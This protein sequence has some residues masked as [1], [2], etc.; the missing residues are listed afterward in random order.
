MDPNFNQ[1]LSRNDP[2]HVDFFVP[3]NITETVVDT[4]DTGEDWSLKRVQQ[5][6]V[7][8]KTVPMK[9]M[10]QHGKKL[11]DLTEEEKALMFPQD[12][13]ESLMPI[14]D[15]MTGAPV[16]TG[17]LSVVQ[18]DSIFQE[19]FGTLGVEANNEYIPENDMD[20]TFLNDQNILPM[21]AYYPNSSQ[22]VRPM[23]IIERPTCVSKGKEVKPGVFVPKRGDSKYIHQYLDEIEYEFPAG[24]NW[25]VGV[26]Q[27]PIPSAGQSWREFAI[28]GF[29][30]N[31]D[32][33][34]MLKKKLEL[35]NSG[36]VWG[37]P[38]YWRVGKPM[39]LPFG[40]QFGSTVDVDGGFITADSRKRGRGLNVANSS[41]IPLYG[42]HGINS[43]V[44]S[45]LC[46]NPLA[47]HQVANCLSLTIHGGFADVQTAGLWLN[48]MKKKA[49]SSNWPD[50]FTVPICTG[51]S[52]PPPLPS[53]P[54]L[55]DIPDS[56]G[57]G[58]GGP[59]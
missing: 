55:P 1:Q 8:N 54:D 38:F 2:S 13:Y 36:D 58:T 43:V 21:G 16:E 15:P 5:A 57:R 23:I 47:T 33:A 26:Y 29:C 41:D 53:R 31:E 3:P 17:E 34:K 39:Q 46:P 56:F 44:F 59:L 50:M 12:P 51:I 52:L 28:A 40:D 19:Q 14:E 9:A 20:M 45:Y 30:V 25:V 24:Q 32:R 4:G 6:I 42:Q 18:D 27:P 49:Q 7:D 11:C 22:R 37:V 10:I 48:K 35:D